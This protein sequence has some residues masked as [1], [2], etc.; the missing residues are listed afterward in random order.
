MD[1]DAGRHSTLGAASVSPYPCVSG[2]PA[3]AQRAAS[4]GGVVAP[5]TSACRSIPLA[6]SAKSAVR[7]SVARPT[8]NIEEFHW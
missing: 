6:T 5:P 8:L 4:S 3:A 7:R 1:S 2:I